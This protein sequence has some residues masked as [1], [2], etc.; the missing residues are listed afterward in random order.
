[1]DSI[2]SLATARAFCLWIWKDFGFPTSIFSDRG[3]QFTSEIWYE[4][5]QLAGTDAAFST[6]FHP[7]TDGQTG[8]ANAILEQYLRTFVAFMQDDWTRWL[9]SAEFATNNHVSETIAVSPFF[10]KSAQHPRMGFEPAGYFGDPTEPVSRKERADAEALHPR[11][12]RKR[13]LQ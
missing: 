3:T 9:P 10:A 5:C 8:R 4:L 7:E 11:D 1:M 12:R 2:D 13:T 6:A